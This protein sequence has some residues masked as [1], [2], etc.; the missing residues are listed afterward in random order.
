[1]GMKQIYNIMVGMALMLG[2]TS[3][4]KEILD[5]GQAAGIA[6]ADGQFIVDYSGEVTTRAIKD[7]AEKGER[8]NSLTYLL[9]MQQENDYV[10]QKRR[11]I[12][13]LNKTDDDGN[14]VYESWPLTRDNMTWEQREALKDTLLVGSNY[15]AVFVANADASLWGSTNSPL[16]NASMPTDGSAAPSYSSA[17]L[18]LPANLAFNDGN[19]F[20]LAEAEI[21][22]TG[23]DRNTPYNCPIMLKRVVTRTDWWFERLPEWI[24]ESPENPSTE[25]NLPEVIKEYLNPLLIRMASDNYDYW[26]GQVVTSVSSFLE[27]VAGI[28]D[29]LAESIVGVE[30]A[31]LTDEQKAEKAK[32]E[33]YAEAMRTLKTQIEG[34]GKE[35]FLQ[36]MFAVDEETG[37]SE[38]LNQVLSYLFGY[39][40]DNATL[41]SDWQKYDISA[42]RTAKVSYKDNVV[43]DRYYLN[44]RWTADGNYTSSPSI[45]IDL[46]GSLDEGSEVTYKGFNWVG[47]LSSAAD[48][49]SEIVLNGD[50]SAEWKIP[51]TLSADQQGKNEKRVYSYHPVY[52]LNLISGWTL[53]K[54]G[55]ISCNMEE[56]LPFDI[57][58]AGDSPAMSAEE[59]GAL[60]EDVNA[61]MNGENATITGF[62]S[63]LS[64]FSLPIELPDLSSMDVLNVESLWEER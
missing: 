10:L 49:V 24:E 4:E 47:F 52:R 20:Y 42:Y 1:M 64:D 60:K 40:N 38:F 39:L 51:F 22:G 14:P 23:Q 55:I 7:N 31:E 17:Y 50:A 16:K 19:M 58:T 3:C 63:S 62:G 26:A 9:Y 43:N 29:G 35:V 18:Q 25:S 21:D 45:A 32:W 6:L 48:W 36:S 30:G 12:P 54:D 28:Y 15:R 5:N 57:L 53:T 44:N 37:D 56:A 27:E 61:K 34:T 33:K 46:E 41:K 59:L 11:E 13:G 8:I 2:A